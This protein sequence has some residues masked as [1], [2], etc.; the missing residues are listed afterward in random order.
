MSVRGAFV[1]VFDI[2]DVA[3]HCIVLI[4]PDG[5]RVVVVIVLRCVLMI[6]VYAP[7]RLLSVAGVIFVVFGVWVVYLCG[8]GFAFRCVVDG[9][10]RFVVFRRAFDRLVLCGVRLR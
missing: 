7:W 4:G 1:L 6:V 5:C 9:V 8:S 3:V 2:I 10:L